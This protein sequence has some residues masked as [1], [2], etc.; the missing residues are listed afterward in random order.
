MSLYLKMSRCSLKSFR[1]VVIMSLGSSGVGFLS[2]VSLRTVTVNWVD[3]SPYVAYC[4]G[5]E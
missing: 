5:K 3:A 4:K 2:T 1:Y